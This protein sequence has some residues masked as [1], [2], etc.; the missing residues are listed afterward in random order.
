MFGQKYKKLEEKYQSLL[1]THEEVLTR[2]R[3]NA[4]QV[5]RLKEELGLT[6]ANLQEMTWDN[7]DLIKELSKAHGEIAQA[8][9]KLELLADQ[10]SSLTLASNKKEEVIN[11]LRGAK[12]AVKKELQTRIL[13]LEERSANQGSL[14]SILESEL[15]KTNSYLERREQEAIDRGEELDQIYCHPTWK[16]VKIVLKSWLS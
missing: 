14:I 2:A 16:Q 4:K 13:E 8:L 12:S 15:E 9:E 3:N 5:T 10:V 11:S 7:E 1:A 6:R